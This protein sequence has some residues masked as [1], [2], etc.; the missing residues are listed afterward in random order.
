MS[1]RERRERRE[2][3]TDRQTERQREKERERYIDRR[4]YTAQEGQSKRYMVGQIYRD[5][6]IK[7][8]YQREI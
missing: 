6:Y 4:K 3:E 2:R 5:Q 1:V 7:R 8:Q